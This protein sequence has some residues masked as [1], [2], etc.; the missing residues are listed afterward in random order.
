MRL[1]KARFMG[2]WEGGQMAEALLGEGIC[3]SVRLGRLVIGR[4]SKSTKKDGTPV[5][6]LCPVT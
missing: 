5:V 6:H 1:L 2:G 3:G 4:I